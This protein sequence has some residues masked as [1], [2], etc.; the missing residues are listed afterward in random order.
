MAA[1]VSELVQRRAVVASG[2]LESVLWRQMNAVSQ[3]IVESA[4]RLIVE[5]CRA[6]V[7]QNL[8]S[9]IDHFEH[10]PLFRGPFGNAFDLLC[11]EDGVH[12]M[13]ETI[14]AARVKL[15]GRLLSIAASGTNWFR[16]RVASG[17]HLPE[18]NLR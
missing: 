16:S 18:L 1:I 8:L 9:S 10:R 4:I 6:G 2:V 14:A 12:A 7:L 11:V 17:F 3:P 15:L 13:N 5:D